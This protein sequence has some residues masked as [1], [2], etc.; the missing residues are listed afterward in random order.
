MRSADGLRRD[1]R[2]VIHNQKASVWK[3]LLLVARSRPAL[4]K[5]LPRHVDEGP[6]LGRLGGMA[7]KIEK[8]AGLFDARRRQ[9][10]PQAP[11][12]EVIA[13]ERLEEIGDA[14]RLGN[15]DCLDRR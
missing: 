12:V 2:P 15:R 7:G 1:P 10:L 6:E 3:H 13:D 8:E 5:L 4:A 14:C 9:H 11:G